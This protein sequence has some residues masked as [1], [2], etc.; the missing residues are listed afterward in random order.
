M[1]RL[2]YLTDEPLEQINRLRPPEGSGRG[3][4]PTSKHREA[5]EGIL[6]SWRTGTPWRDLP[7]AYGPWHTIDRRWPRWIERGGWEDILRLLKRLKGVDLKLVVRAST[8]VRAPQHAAGAAKKPAI[9]P[10]VAPAAGCLPKSRPWARRKQRGW[11][12]GLRR[13]SWEMG[14]SAK[15]SSLPST[16][17]TGCNGPPGTR[18][19]TARPSAPSSKSRASR[20]L[21]P[22]R[23]TAWRAS[24]M[25]KKAISNATKSSVAS[26]NSNHSAELPLVL[27]NS[28]PTCSASSPSPSSSSCFAKFVNPA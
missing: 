2:Y 26:T 27:K 28:K 11:L 21:F 12:S 24:A 22:P 10:S 20:R 8:V 7:P 1:A 18:P 3:R 23:P 9:R 17:G 13:G 5:R 15:R 6:H 14:L 16:R 4:P 19:L 25:T